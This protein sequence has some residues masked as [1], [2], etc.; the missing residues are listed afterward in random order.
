NEWSARLPS[1]LALL[2]VAVAF[3]TVARPAFGP[4]GSRIAALIWL[5][6]FGLI[7]KGRLIEIEALYISFFALA[8]IFWLAFWK[9]KRSPWLTWLVPWIFLGLG[10]LAKG[11]THVLFFY[12]LVIAIL[13][14]TAELRTFWNLPHTIGIAIMLSIFAAWAV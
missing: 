14:K 7:E 6:S 10:L 5:T 11:P 8:F 3:V 13:W 9:Q 2:V 1:A 12:A 4:R